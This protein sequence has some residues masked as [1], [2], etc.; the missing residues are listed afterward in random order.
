MA[1]VSVVALVMTTRVVVVP[2]VVVVMAA[3]QAVM[4][5]AMV[6]M[7]VVVTQDG[8][9]TIAVAF[10]TR[11]NVSVSCNT[12]GWQRLCCPVR[13]DHSGV[14]ACRVADC[15]RSQA[16][17]AYRLLIPLTMA[18]VS[19]VPLMAATQVVVPLR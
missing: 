3:T 9:A 1:V 5:M 13:Q 4:T 6:V 18:V 8:I 10:D 16:L 17:V 15:H 14:S 7:M 19:V 12:E 11:L 2:L